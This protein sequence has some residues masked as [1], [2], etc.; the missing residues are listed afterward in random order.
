MQ[1]DRRSRGF[2]L[3]DDPWM[4]SGEFVVGRDGLIRL[5]YVYNYCE[6]YPDPRVFITA[7]RL[8]T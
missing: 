5:A 3:V 6:D 2:N 7:G 1:E 4:Q 8:S